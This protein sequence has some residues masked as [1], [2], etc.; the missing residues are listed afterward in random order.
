MWWLDCW[1]CFRECVLYVKGPL[2]HDGPFVVIELN[3][4]FGILTGDLNSPKQAAIRD[5]AP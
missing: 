4:G 1:Y 3:A 5:A 2:C